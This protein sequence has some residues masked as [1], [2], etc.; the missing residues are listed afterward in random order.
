LPLEFGTMHQRW[1]IDTGRISANILKP[2][3][4]P[5]SVNHIKNL[6]H[7][8]LSC[9]VQ[10]IIFPEFE[11]KCPEIPIRTNTAGKAKTLPFTMISPSIHRKWDSISFAK[12]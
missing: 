4:N 10:S 2:S 11:R 12:S 7:H 3:S 6:S 5:E 1:R 8:I 9:L